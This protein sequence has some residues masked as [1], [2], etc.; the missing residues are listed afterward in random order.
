MMLVIFMIDYVLQP[1]QERNN[2]KVVNN[3]TDVRD[4]IYQKEHQSNCLI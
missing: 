2:I 3:N 4:P 1:L